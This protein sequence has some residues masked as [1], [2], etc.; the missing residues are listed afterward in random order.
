MK[1]D[2]GLTSQEKGEIRRKA[3]EEWRPWFAWYP[4]RVGSRQCVWLETIERRFY[5]RGLNH[6]LFWEAVYGLPE[7]KS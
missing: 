6:P 3:A 1:F 7:V 5:T 2:C 4:V